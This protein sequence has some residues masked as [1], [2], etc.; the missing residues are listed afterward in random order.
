M[1]I[2]SMLKARDEEVAKARAQAHTGISAAAYLQGSVTQ[3]SVHKRARSLSSSLSDSE[4]SDSTSSGDSHPPRA[5]SSGGSEDELLLKRLQ[6]RKEQG[7]ERKIKPAIRPDASAPK[8]QT[9]TATTKSRDK[10]SHVRKTQAKKDAAL[11]DAEAASADADVV[12][13]IELTDDDA[14]RH[15][16][17]KRVKK[18]IPDAAPERTRK[19]KPSA[20]AAASYERVPVSQAMRTHAASLSY[21]EPTDF[22]GAVLQLCSGDW[23]ASE[24]GSNIR[25]F[26]RKLKVES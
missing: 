5:A 21:L 16:G 9:R 23:K 20:H 17:R 8:L 2:F 1:E 11:R 24:K 15:S 25:A 14:P 19:R 26:L 7:Q 13:H 10:G 6:R 12:Q 3:A 4:A 18:V 22:D